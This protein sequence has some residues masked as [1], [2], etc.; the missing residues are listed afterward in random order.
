[1]T[2]DQT[3]A[4]LQGLSESNGDQLAD[5][6]RAL[7]TN[8]VELRASGARSTSVVANVA[9]EYAR[10]QRT[11]SAVPNEKRFLLYLTGDDSLPMKEIADTKTRFDDGIWPI[12]GSRLFWLGWSSLY[13]VIEIQLTHLSASEEMYRLILADMLRLLDARDLRAFQGW[14]E[15]LAEIPSPRGSYFWNPRWFSSPRALDASLD[16]GTFF[17]KEQGTSWKAGADKAVK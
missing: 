10:E 2:R 16:E 7:E 4:A 6:L 3:T 8:E 1:M 17:W 5:Y 14:R 13:D 15:V 11:L 12:A 9:E